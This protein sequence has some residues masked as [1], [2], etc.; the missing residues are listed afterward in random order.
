[1]VSIGVWSLA[2][3]T[4]LMKAGIALVWTPALVET[5]CH[6]PKTGLPATHGDVE[7]PVTVQ[8]P[9]LTRWVGDSTR[10]LSGLLMTWS[11]PLM[12][13]VA[14]STLTLWSTPVQQLSTTI[15]ALL[16]P[17]SLNLSRICCLV[18]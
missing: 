15:E 8:G 12:P 17:T 6:S 3:L 16:T 4:T 9:S 2:T 10:S 11:T 1:M 7:V 18:L 5:V 13:T 14:L